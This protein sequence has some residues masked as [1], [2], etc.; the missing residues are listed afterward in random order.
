MGREGKGKEERGKK[1]DAK[2]FFTL[3]GMIYNKLKLCSTTGMQ[4]KL[5]FWL[6]IFHPVLSVRQ[7]CCVKEIYNWVIEDQ[8]KICPWKGEVWGQKCHT[9]HIFLH[10]WA[11]HFV[12]RTFLQHHGEYGTKSPIIHFFM[13]TQQKTNDAFPEPKTTCNSHCSQ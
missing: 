3:R 6:H 12:S 10:F 13:I 2:T 5:L 9:Q 11:L 7:R 1:R 8:I 4:N